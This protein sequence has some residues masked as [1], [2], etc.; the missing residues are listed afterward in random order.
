MAM[1][2]S[3]RGFLGTAQAT[4]GAA[5][6]FGITGTSVLGSDRSGGSTENTTENE[7]V[8]PGF[9]SQDDE[10][11]EEVVGASHARFDRVKELVTERPALA[12][13]SWDWGF[14][15]WESALGAASHMGRKDI[16][17][18]LMSHGAR[19]NLFTFAMLGQIE[20]VKGILEANPGIQR[21]P[22][23]H[24][25]TLLQHARSRLR[26]DDL[27]EN[28]RAASAKMVEYLESVGDADIGAKSLEI[29]VAQKK[30]YLGRYAFGF[31][32]DDSLTVKLNRR[33]LLAIQRGDETSRTIHLVETHTFAPAGAPAVRLRFEVRDG[34]AQS[35]TVHDPAPIVKAVR[36][37]GSSHG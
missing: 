10:A 13:A 2:L 29:T 14:G 30:I 3:R 20:V 24:G 26:H 21:T 27:S 6:L 15:D 18:F 4:C 17:E 32:T 25:I 9:P 8:A 11:V 28:E 31:G 37:G 5:A 1:E 16:A 35:V 33:G 22:G 23:P 19:P 7:S 34:V 12:K 36:T